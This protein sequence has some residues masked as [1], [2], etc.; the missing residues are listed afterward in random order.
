MVT[1]PTRSM[2]IARVFELLQECKS[3]LYVDE[4]ECNRSHDDLA[5]GRIL[6]GMDSAS[7]SR[8]HN[9]HI[10]IPHKGATPGQILERMKLYFPGALEKN[11]AVRMDSASRGTTDISTRNPPSWESL[12]RELEAA[13]GLGACETFRVPAPARNCAFHNFQVSIS[14][15]VLF[16][17]DGSSKEDLTD[18]IFAARNTYRRMHE[19]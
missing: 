6:R 17:F 8:L 19:A 7:E 5:K 12:K 9:S 3:E 11:V 10:F 13:N 18:F 15:A 14:A 2:G 4:N 16:L 1:M